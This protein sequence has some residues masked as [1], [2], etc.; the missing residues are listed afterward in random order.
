MSRL[1]IIVSIKN[2]TFYFIKII[3]IFI[4]GTYA[5]YAPGMGTPLSNIDVGLYTYSSITTL[6]YGVGE[7]LGQRVSALV[8]KPGQILNHR[9]PFD[10]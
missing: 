9:S 2:S 3:N 1:V 10:L 6:K 4:E 7:Q 8:L 5:P